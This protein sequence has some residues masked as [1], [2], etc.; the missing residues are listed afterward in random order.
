MGRYSC[1]CLVV[2]YVR[3]P[4]GQVHRSLLTGIILPLHEPNEMAVWSLQQPLIENYHEALVGCL[5]PFLERQPG[6]LRVIFESIVAAWPQ[7]FQSNTP[8][9]RR[10]RFV[11][12]L[13]VCDRARSCVG[14]PYL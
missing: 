6:M 7:G 13:C 12:L 11:T 1:A 2:A 4:R 8:K 5:I 9:V 10:V 3:A 14:A